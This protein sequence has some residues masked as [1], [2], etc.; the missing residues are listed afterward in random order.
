MIDVMDGTSIGGTDLISAA[1]PR[2]EVKD[3]VG[4][5]GCLHGRSDDWPYSWY[6]AAPG[7]G[8]CVPAWSLCSVA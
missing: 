7:L 3:T 4:G 5:G 1:A 8:E 2:V 6:E